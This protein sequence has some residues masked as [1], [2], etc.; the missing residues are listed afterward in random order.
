MTNQGCGYGRFPPDVDAV[1][2][3]EREWQEQV[4][5][6]AKLY[7][8][9]HFHAHDSRRSPAGFPDLVLWRERVIYAEL[10]T[11]TGSLTGDQERVIHQLIDAG[12]EVYVWRPRDLDDVHRVLTTR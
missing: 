2:M 5:E 3:L 1:A 9:I 10:K 8:W 7:R 11:N 4:L 12:A 6:L